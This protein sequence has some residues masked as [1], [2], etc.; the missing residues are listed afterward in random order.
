MTK[1]Q[2][3][4]SSMIELD[5]AVKTLENGN[6]TLDE[7]IKLYKRAITL[8]HKCNKFLEEAKQKIEIIKNDNYDLDNIDSGDDM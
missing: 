8:S 6:L 1:K 3:F 7:S 4:E 5:N 2:T